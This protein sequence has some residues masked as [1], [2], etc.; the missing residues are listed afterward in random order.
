[1]LREGF[2]TVLFITAQSQ[3][4]Y[5][6]SAVGAIVGLLLAS[7]MGWSLFYWGIKINIRLFFQIMGIFLLLIVAGL[8]VS[9][10]KN[11]DGAM[12]ILSQINPNYQNICLFDRDS[13][14]LGI[15]VWN[16]SNFL[17]DGKFPGILLKTLFGYREQIYLLQLICYFLFLGIVGK[18]YFSSL[19]PQKETK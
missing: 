5:L 1:V 15:K 3:E 7:L 9:A 4:D 17:P 14:L 19:N 11:F 10:L 6:S 2:E 16:A 13:C 12:T 18:L 8:V